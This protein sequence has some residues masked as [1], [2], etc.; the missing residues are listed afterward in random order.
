MAT[1]QQ[2]QKQIITY[3]ESIGA[4]TV[5]TIKCSKSG[6][7]DVL[8]CLN[9]HFLS[10]EVKLPGQLSTV[11]LIQQYNLD[12]VIQS[13]GIAFA[14]TSVADVTNQLQQHQLLPPMEV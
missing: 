13:G 3:L 4:Y 2:V 14:A 12:L 9:G 8:A 7:S 10:I 11:T 1:E 6:V 5:V